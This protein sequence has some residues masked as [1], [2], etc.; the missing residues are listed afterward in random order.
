MHSLKSIDS[1]FMEFAHGL[2]KGALLFE[3]LAHKEQLFLGGGF[4]AH[5]SGISRTDSIVVENENDGS[6]E[7]RK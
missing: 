2:V 6:L 5:V 4:L 7:Y 3:M 1:G